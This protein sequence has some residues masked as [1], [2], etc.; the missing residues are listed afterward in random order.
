MK[1]HLWKRLLLQILGLTLCY[2]A[3]A[4]C[5]WAAVGQGPV[6]AFEYTLSVALQIKMGTI[7][8]IFQGLAL[9]GQ[10]IIEGKQFR[11]YQ[12]LQLPLIIYG[13][14]VMNLVLYSLLMPLGWEMQYIQRLLA[15]LVGLMM[16]VTGVVIVFEADL[17]RVPWEGFLTLLGGKTGRTL[18]QL[19]RWT[20]GFLMAVTVL[21]CLLDHQALT[22]REGTVIT[23]LVSGFAIDFLKSIVHRLVNG[24]TA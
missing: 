3:A 24:K 16:N 10:W 1:D 23:L 12:L 21:I 20:E 7:A 4:V 22:I 17:V 13:S 9:A 18:G 2:S 15:L 5:A 19:K 6:G 14:V 11:Y 8:W